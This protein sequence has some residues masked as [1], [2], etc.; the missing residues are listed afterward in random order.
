MIDDR[1]TARPLPLPAPRQCSHWDLKNSIRNSIAIW[2]CQ[3]DP[4]GITPA[5]IAVVVKHSDEKRGIE[6]I[7]HPIARSM[8]PATSY[9]RARQ[10]GQGE[11]F[12]TGCLSTE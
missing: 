10:L 5:N 3:C 4:M 7:W 11:V 1:L 9:W 8:H 6:P 2:S 12:Y